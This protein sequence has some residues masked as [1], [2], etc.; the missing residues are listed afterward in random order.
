MGVL[1]LRNN[2]VTRGKNQQF[3]TFR[4]VETI[5]LNSNLCNFFQ[6]L[7]NWQI[8]LWSKIEQSSIKINW[9]KMKTL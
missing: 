1:V 6:N 5:L 2:Q 8:E 3:N 9:I 4:I 7:F